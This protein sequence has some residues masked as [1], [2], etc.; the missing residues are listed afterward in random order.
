MQRKSSCLIRLGLIRSLCKH[1]GLSKPPAS[2]LY[3]IGNSAQRMALPQRET[4]VLLHGLARTSRSMNTLAKALRK[5][6]YQVINQGYPSNRHPVETLAMQAIPAALKQCSANSPVHFVTHSMGG[7]L[8]RHYLSQHKI[9]MLARVVML[10]P[11][12][13]GT[14]LVDKLSELL[15]TRQIFRLLNG[16]AGTQLGTHPDSLPNRLGR[17]E[18]ESGIIA[19]SRSI[20][21]LLSALLPKPHDGKV[22]VA[23]TKLEGMSD[24]IT[25]RASHTFMMNNPQVIEQVLQFLQHGAFFR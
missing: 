4:V 22:S 23:S 20:S 12:N 17:A 16:P 6:R 3:S 13:K 9:K 1:Q 2:T 14:E 7:I 19:G 24:H 8:V 21:P 25:L 5:H 15:A 18:F 10:A 11:P